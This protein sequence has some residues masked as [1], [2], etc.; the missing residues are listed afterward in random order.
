MPTNDNRIAVKNSYADDWETFQAV[1]ASLISDR[2]SSAKTIIAIKSLANGKYLS[3]MDPANLASNKMDIDEAE[4]FI[5]YYGSG[6]RIALK[7]KSEPQFLTA[8]ER[9]QAAWMSTGYLNDQKVF[10]VVSLDDQHEIGR[11]R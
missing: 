3:A 5:V 2:A 11:K 10:E 1:D 4:C 7:L 6:N 8:D 9:N